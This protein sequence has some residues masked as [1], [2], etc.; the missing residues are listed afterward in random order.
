MATAIIWVLDTSSIIEIRRSVAVAQ[1]NSVFAGM[2]GLVA[3]DR[4]L[5]P[6][7]VVDELERVADPNAPDA[8]YL[9]AR[10]NAVKA[11][12]H[13][14]SLQ[15]VKDVLAVVPEVLDPDKDAGA[16]EADPYILAVAARLRVEGKDARVVTQ[17]TKDTP[18]KM[19]LN[20]ACG[21]LGIPSVPL[22]AFLQF[23][24]IR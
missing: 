21:L 22:S 6:K 1:R 18:R 14:P 13:D 20:T 9:W 8:Q 3:A 4:I 5:F 16:E 11:N 2:V 12:A 17:E 10:Q 15:E 23:E 24:K 7:Q 19:S